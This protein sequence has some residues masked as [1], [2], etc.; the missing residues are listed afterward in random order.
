[1][2]NLRTMLR[3]LIWFSLYNAQAKLGSFSDIL[4]FKWDGKHQDKSWSFGLVFS[5]T[6]LAEGKGKRENRNKRKE[7]GEGKSRM[8][9][10]KEKKGKRKEKRRERIKRVKRIKMESVLRGDV[11]WLLLFLLQFNT[12]LTFKWGTHTWECT[13]TGCYTCHH[14][15]QTQLSCLCWIKQG[16]GVIFSLCHLTQDYLLSSLR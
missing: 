3:L 14:S 9:S 4:V 15:L 5:S 13:V 6:V 16:L 2:F 7:K 11:P 8:G 1:M 12:L 10:L